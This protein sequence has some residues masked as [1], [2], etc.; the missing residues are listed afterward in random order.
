MS[1]KLKPTPGVWGVYEASCASAQWPGI[2]ADGH[3]VVIFGARRDDGG[4]RGRNKREAKS[5]ARLIAEAGT[6]HNESGLSPRELLEGYRELRQALSKFYG[7]SDEPY[8]RAVCDTLAKH[9][10]V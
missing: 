1:E 4:V 9:K 6:V 10:E 7:E 3:A 5:N 8:S 2:D